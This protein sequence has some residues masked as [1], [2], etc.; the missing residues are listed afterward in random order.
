MFIAIRPSCDLLS[1]P[2]SQMTIIPLQCHSKTQDPG[3]KISF[4]STGFCRLIG[5]VHTHRQKPASTQTIECQS[6]Q[7]QIWNVSARLKYWMALMQFSWNISKPQLYYVW[8]RLWQQSGLITAV[9]LVPL[10]GPSLRQMES[11]SIKLPLRRIRF[12]RV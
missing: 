12:G 1:L 6:T 4:T 9:G 10:S 7:R 8:E 2:G 11:V 3:S 5:L